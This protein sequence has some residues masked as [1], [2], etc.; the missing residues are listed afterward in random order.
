ML[1][2]SSLNSSMQRQIIEELVLNHGQKNVSI[3][4][5]KIQCQMDK[6]EAIGLLDLPFAILEQNMNN[7]KTDDNKKSLK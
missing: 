6:T 7:N 1:Y 3:R 5:L 4:Y 2:G